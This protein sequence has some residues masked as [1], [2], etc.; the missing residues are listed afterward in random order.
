MLSPLVIR[1]FDNYVQGIQT[2]LANDYKLICLQLYTVFISYNTGWEI[3]DNELYLSE[4]TEISTCRNHSFQLRQEC[5]NWLFKK[6]MVDRFLTYGVWTKWAFQ[7]DYL[8]KCIKKFE[9]WKQNHK[10]KST[11]LLK[12]LK[13]KL[14]RHLWITELRSS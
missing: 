6:K 1:G 9:H 4:I 7:Q 2:I 5:N 3:Y 10:A 12:R 13:K 8:S 14:Q 11:P